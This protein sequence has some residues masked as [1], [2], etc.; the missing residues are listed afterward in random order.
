M[1][2]RLLL[3][4][5]LGFGASRASALTAEGALI[6]GLELTQRAVARGSDEAAHATGHGL[7]ALMGGATPVFSASMHEVQRAHVDGS[8]STVSNM[9]DETDRLLGQGGGAA[10]LRGAQRLQRQMDGQGR[11]GFE[12]GLGDTEMGVFRFTR[13]K[14]AEGTIGLNTA[15]AQMGRLIGHAFAAATL[16]HEAGH[17]ADAAI[18]SSGVIDGEIPAFQL[19]YEWLRFVD[20]TG[21]KLALLRVAL[22][23]QHAAYPSRVTRM[24][25]DYARTLD[26]LRGTGGKPE[27]IK[28]L[29]DQLG[30][31]E[32]EGKTAIPVPGA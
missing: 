30:Y 11:L 17:A 18:E 1:R 5:F 22:A 32:G 19:E 15:L 28:A 21:E 9:L 25:L 7:E 2:L 16:F 6:Q 10:D 12:Q 23:E 27:K 20:P 8:G 31:V 26:V 24:A 13:G 14:G 29:V 4:A 3:A